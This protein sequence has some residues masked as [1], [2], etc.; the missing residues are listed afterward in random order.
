MLVLGPS[1][2]FKYFYNPFNLTIASILINAIVHWAIERREPDP[3]T[4]I[5]RASL[6]LLERSFGRTWKQTTARRSY[7]H[8]ISVEYQDQC[9]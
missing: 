2:L 9:F 4:S 7:A 1:V 8:S 3:F 5:T 6:G